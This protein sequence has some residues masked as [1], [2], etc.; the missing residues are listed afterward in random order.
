MFDPRMALGG[1]S[2]GRTH[3][4]K[5]ARSNDICDDDLSVIPEVCEPKGLIA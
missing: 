5:A 3:R 4:Q 2:A 1:A